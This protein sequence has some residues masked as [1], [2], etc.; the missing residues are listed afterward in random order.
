MSI[1]I[2]IAIKHYIQLTYICKVYCLVGGE[3]N[4]RVKYIIIYFKKNSTNTNF[5]DRTDTCQYTETF[6]KNTSHTVIKSGNGLKCS[7]VCLVAQLC[8]TFWDLVDWSPLGSSVH[9][10]L[11]A[12]ILEW[13]AIPSPDHL[14][15]PGIELRSLALKV[16]SLSSEPP[17]NPHI[18]RYHKVSFTM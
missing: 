7:C 18:L 15:N 1:N 2:G 8:L 14:P 3:A 6:L 4:F 16:D 5:M 13:V 10:N 17:G 9:R 11:Q 12:R